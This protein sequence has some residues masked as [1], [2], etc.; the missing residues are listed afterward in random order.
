MKMRPD[1]LSNMIARVFRHPLHT[2]ILTAYQIKH[3]FIYL[4]AGYKIISRQMPKNKKNFS[5]KFAKEIQL[6]LYIR[7]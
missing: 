5:V 1:P 2:L 6:E 3:S 7:I 4:Q